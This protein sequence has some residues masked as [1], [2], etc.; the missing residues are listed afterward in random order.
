MEAVDKKQV[1]LQSFN[2]KARFTGIHMCQSVF[3]N[4]VAALMPATLL[5]KGLWHMCFP[6]NFA[7]FLRTPI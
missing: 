1:S 2:T 5:K 4:K 6:V 7:K 3:Y